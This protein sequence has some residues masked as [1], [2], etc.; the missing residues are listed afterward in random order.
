MAGGAGGTLGG[1]AGVGTG[2]A[3]GGTGGATGGTGGATGGT[4]GA[5]GGTGGATSGTGGTLAGAGGT[6]AGAGGTM[7]G[8]GGTAAG[9]GGMNS[10]GTNSGGAGAGGSGAGLGGMTTGG[11]GGVTGGAGAGGSAS[12]AG[13]KGN[14]GAGGMV[15]DKNS[16]PNT[17]GWIGCSMGENTAQGYVR[18]GGTRMWGP[19]GNGAQ[20]V[21]SWT[22][23]NSA[24]WQRFDRQVDEHGAPVAVWVMICVGQGGATDAEVRS[25]V[26]NAKMHAPGAVIY[27]TGQPVYHEGHVCTI[28]GPGAPE[29]TDQQA[30]M[31]APELGAIYPG[32]LGPLNQGEYTSDSCHASTSGQDKLGTQ[33]KGWWG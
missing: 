5:T 18:I 31:L 32:T 17:M 1:T 21:Q 19:Y 25:M 3:T 13:G 7:A 28:A 2:G 33:V 6:L 29:R 9:A 8:A 27:L 12:G 4:G 16:G 14:A 20:I 10:G 26:N 30:E 23:G 11:Q 22:S 15:D 24:A